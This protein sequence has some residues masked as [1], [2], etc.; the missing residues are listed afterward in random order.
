MRSGRPFRRYRPLCANLGR[1]SENGA[2]VFR[3]ATAKDCIEKSA[4]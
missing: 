1:E 3:G 4:V 2:L